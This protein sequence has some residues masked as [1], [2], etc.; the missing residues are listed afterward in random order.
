MS[1]KGLGLFQPRYKTPD[2]SWAVDEDAVYN[3]RRV[4]PAD[5]R[6]IAAA[7]PATDPRREFFFGPTGKPR[8]ELIQTT[9]Y[10]DYENAK[11]VA[12]DIQRRWAVDI[13]ALRSH[14][15]PRDVDEA[16]ERIDDWRSSALSRAQGFEVEIAILDHWAAGERLRGRSVREPG[17]PGLD[18]GSHRWA[19]SYFD[20]NPQAERGNDVPLATFLLIDRLTDAEAD[21]ARTREVPGFDAAMA[22]ALGSAVGPQ[23]RTAVRS[24]FA[25]AWRE[26]VQAQEAERR[27]AANIINMVE[28]FGSTAVAVPRRPGAYTPQAGDRTVGELLD[29]YGTADRAR[30]GPTADKETAVVMRALREFL[31]QDQPVRAVSRTDARRVHELLGKTPKNAAKH[32][33][34]QPLLTAIE[35]GGKD[36]R[37]ALSPNTVSKYVNY[38]SSFW[39]WAIL[40]KDGWAEINPFEGLAGEDDPS[41]RRRGFTNEELVKLF[42]RLSKYKSRDLAEFWV[43]ALNLNGS[44]MSELLQLRTTDVKTEQGVTYLDLSKFDSTGRRDASK[45]L[46]NRGSERLAPIHPLVIEAGFLDLVE[47]RRQSG[48]V[49]LFPDHKPYE[50]DGEIDWSHYFSKWIGGVI[51]DA[52]SPDPALVYHSFR[53]T[54]RERGRML[55]YSPEVINALGGWA[56]KSV[57]ERYGVNYIATLDEQLARIDFNP[58]RL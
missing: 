50:K 38:A 1:G 24:A 20:A 17:A 12:R 49:R 44:R 33:P 13:A 22:E 39:K 2:G 9:G 37:P 58:L 42:A 26:V 41:V 46:K 23:V 15:N 56:A 29:A 35:R 3:V 47:R 52:V 8:A 34:G 27:Y 7:L 48:D 54:L 40:E 32:Y 11:R 4:I 36:G 18:F 57:G 28:N 10:N 31:G 51:D 5:V 14:G 16:L 6:T 43:P 53:H 55:N 30:R 21:P 25:K 45:S 19:A